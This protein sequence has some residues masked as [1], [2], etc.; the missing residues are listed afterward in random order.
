MKT[1]C[2][3]LVVALVSAWG[4]C[5]DVILRFGATGT[6]GVVYTGMFHSPLV[7]EFGTRFVEAVVFFDRETD[8][9]RKVGVDYGLSVCVAWGDLAGVSI[10]GWLPLLFFAGAGWDG[11]AFVEAGMS[12]L[13]VDMSL[14]IPVDPRRPVGVFVSFAVPVV[15]PQVAR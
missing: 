13:A 5:G 4:S 2:V 12:L 1:L 14:R 6:M 10:R 7:G 11:G 8:D 9:G 15:L 3:F